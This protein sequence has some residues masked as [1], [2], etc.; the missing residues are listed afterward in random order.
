M[1]GYQTQIRFLI[2]GQGKNIYGI[3][4]NIFQK[5]LSGPMYVFKS[6]VDDVPKAMNN[7]NI[8]FGFIIKDKCSMEYGI[9]RINHLGASA[10]FYNNKNWNTEIYNIPAKNI[11]V[12][13]FEN[14]NTDIVIN[15]T[16]FGDYYI[17]IKKILNVYLG[18]FIIFIFIY[19][20]YCKIIN[21]IK[22][23][24]N[25]TICKNEDEDL[26]CTIC[27][28]DIKKKEKIKILACNHIFHY[29]CI[30]EWLT[31]GKTCPNCN[32]TVV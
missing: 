1:K 14:I 3:A 29:D 12:D 22:N 5:T 27:L 13:I 23:K 9:N 15:T 2:N 18:V 16:I 7:S 4:N 32:Q 26:S 25:Y 19:I 28:E 31:H 24:S 8:W 20:V 30:S 11:A 10:A 21:K 6:C 17:Y